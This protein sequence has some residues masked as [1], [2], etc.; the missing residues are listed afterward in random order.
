MSFFGSLLTPTKKTTSNPRRL[1]TEDVQ[2]ERKTIPKRKDITPVESAKDSKRNRPKVPTESALL[3]ILGDIIR[4]TKMKEEELLKKLRIMMAE[5]LD[6]KL[7]QKLAK[8]KENDDKSKKEIAEKVERYKREKNIV[9]SNL[10]ED[11]VEET[12]DLLMKA[13][14]IFEKMG[15]HGIEVDD[16]YRLGKRK[17]NGKPRP[18]LVK[19][20]RNYQKRSVMKEKKKLKGEKI[21]INEDLTFEER[22][23][24]KTLRD[25]YRDFSKGSKDYRMGI[26]NGKMVIWKNGVKSAEYSGRGQCGGGTAANN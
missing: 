15:I 14:D 4:T 17:N 8:L 23:V 20:I 11:E 3:A 2:S 6:E 10:Q 5:L 22:K 7:D 26:R 18:L 19:L 21:Y 9:I 16:I 25:K 1:Q 13:N 12:D 24:E